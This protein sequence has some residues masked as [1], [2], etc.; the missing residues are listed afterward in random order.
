[1]NRLLTCTTAIF[2]VLLAACAGPAPTP[3]PGLEVLDYGRDREIQVAHDVDWNSYSKIILHTAEIEFREN[4]QRDQERTYKTTFRE[5]DM[6][7]FKAAVS[8]QFAKVMYKKLSD[9]DGHELTS[10]SGTGVMRFIPRITDLDIQGPGWVQDSIVESMFNSKGSMTIEVV[11]RDSISGKLLA[12]AWQDQSDP[13]EGYMET[14]NTVNNTVAFR[15][16]MQSWANWLLA[17]LDKA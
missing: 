5:E 2:T 16:M 9:W 8:G 10:E 15:L 7:K 6:E 12:V 11:I 17:E 13:Q 1:M 4:W 14:T 3:E